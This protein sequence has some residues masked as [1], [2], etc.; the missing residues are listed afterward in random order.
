[1]ASNKRQK[2]EE[3]RK[4]HQEGGD[5][6]SPVSPAQMDWSPYFPAFTDRDATK[7]VQEGQPKPLI[8]PVTVADIGC[9]FGGLL[10]AL[11]PM[12]PNELILG[13]EIRTQVTEFVQDRIS[14]LR[15]QHAP[16]TANR[17]IIF[18]RFTVRDNA[19]ESTELSTFA[20]PDEKAKEYLI[21]SDK[22]N[23]SDALDELKT[24]I[25]TAARPSQ[26]LSFRGGNADRIWVANLTPEQADAI[27]KL[28]GVLSIE[29]NYLSATA[30][31]SGETPQYYDPTTSTI[32][33]IPPPTP[34]ANISVLRANTMKF[35]PN[36]FTRHQLSTIF[37][38]FPDPHFKARKHKARIVSSTLCAEYAYVLRPGGCVYTITDVEELAL[39]MRERFREFGGKG[40]GEKMFVEVEVPEEEREGEWIGGDSGGGGE[41]RREVARLVRCIREETEEGKKVKR[42]GG[43]KF[44][45]VWR[46]REDPKWPDEVDEGG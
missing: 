41:Q 2:R 3:Y 7:N 32:T 44:V 45:S 5:G 46:R 15:A 20:N 6:T 12:L 21:Y 35:L 14:A 31:Q 34:Y 17:K 8:K 43:M 13:M 39:W 10:V 4:S 36:F 24:M 16:F 22:D 11:A 23:S 33:S 18:P 42:N 9:G 28:D 40:A 27:G 37:L 19:Y 38:C 26:L 29:E 25:T 30:T 1:M